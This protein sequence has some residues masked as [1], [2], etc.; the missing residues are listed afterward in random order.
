ML[1]PDVL[2]CFSCS[3]K[4]FSSLPPELLADST[5]ES[6]CVLE[7]MTFSSPLFH[8]PPPSNCQDLQLPAL[9]FFSKLSLSYQNINAVMI[10][11]RSLQVPDSVLAMGSF[12]HGPFLSVMRSFHTQHHQRPFFLTHQVC[13]VGK[14]NI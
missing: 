10:S 1:P 8:P 7:G 6:A 11:F 9:L 13:F 12:P 4:V 5:A 14:R 2:G 3:G